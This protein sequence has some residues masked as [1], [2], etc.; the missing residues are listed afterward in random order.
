MGW[1][2]RGRLEKVQLPQEVNS[3][4]PEGQ[5]G[6]GSC[7]RAQNS[8]GT[9]RGKQHRGRGSSAT[10]EDESLQKAQTF[11]QQASSRGGLAQKG[12]NHGLGRRDVGVVWYVFFVGL[13][14]SICTSC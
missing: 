11:G 4:S 2:E 13:D 6:P 3:R 9:A 5:R 10:A 1:M 14:I 7:V 12:E 8:C